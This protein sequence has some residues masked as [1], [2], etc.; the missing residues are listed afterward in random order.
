MLIRGRL[1]FG[2]RSLFFVI[3]I[4]ALPLAWL[5]I[6]V[7]RAHVRA[8]AVQEIGR[9]GRQVW[10][11]DQ[12]DESGIPRI[13][14]APASSWARRVFGEQMFVSV[15]KVSL[16]GTKADDGV[17]EYLERLPQL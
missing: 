2:T 4:V 5:S 7:G 6:A 8:N 15:T 11:S 3:F 13:V 14:T 9:L 16:K 1:R 17:F 10:Y 12:L